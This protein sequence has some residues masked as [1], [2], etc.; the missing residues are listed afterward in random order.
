MENLSQT[1]PTPEQL[2]AFGLGQVSFADSARIESHVLSC[3]SCAQAVKAVPNDHL[4]AVLQQSAV[5][6][7]TETGVETVVAPTA[8]KGPVEV[9]AELARH[10]RY[11]I[12]ELLGSGGMGAVYKAEHLLMERPV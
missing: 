3:D 11:R 1:H 4:I 8:A 2:T 9:P 12:V 6:L 10:T 5:T 7:R